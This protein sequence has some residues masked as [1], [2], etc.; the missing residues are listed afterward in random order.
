M[1][2]FI[3]QSFRKA[4]I[5]KLQLLAL[6]YCLEH[7]QG[8]ANAY[9]CFYLSRTEATWHEAWQICKKH[10]LCFANFE[11]TTEY[12]VLARKMMSIDQA[13]YWFGFK[14]EYG[15]IRAIS[16]SIESILKYSPRIKKQIDV[17]DNCGYINTQRDI[18][19]TDCNTK[20]RFACLKAVKCFNLGMPPTTVNEAEVLPGIVPCKIKPQIREKLELDSKY[21]DEL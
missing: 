17:N 20:K 7:F 4:V 1:P 18:S 11:S 16:T 13:D 21:F 19:T 12:N 8:I 9:R 3:S 5:M 10:H 15:I 2:L 14:D 6:V